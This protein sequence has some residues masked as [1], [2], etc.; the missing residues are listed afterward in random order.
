MVVILYA[1][2]DT[3]GNPFFLIVSVVERKM[4]KHIEVYH[5]TQDKMG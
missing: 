4:S 2:N 3:Q 5:E 1:V